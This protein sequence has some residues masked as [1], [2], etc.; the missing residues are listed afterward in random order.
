MASCTVHT[1]LDCILHQ[2][3]TKLKPRGHQQTQ[4]FFFP[5]SFFVFNTKT[6]F[7]VLHNLNATVNP[8]KA[9]ME[10]FMGA[11]LFITQ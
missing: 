5:F 4:P 3:S 9:G 1:L 7:L 8:K 10:I 11:V 2:H 6:S